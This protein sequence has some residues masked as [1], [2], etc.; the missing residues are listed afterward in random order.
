MNENRNTHTVTNLES[1]SGNE[2][3]AA[4]KVERP[5]PPYCLQIHVIRKRLAD[6]DGLSA[7][8]CID[9]LIKA[10]ILPDDGPRFVK[11]VEYTQEKG[12]EEKTVITIVGI[13]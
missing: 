6:I 10:G 7:K 1:N 11:K 12:E 9:G 8:Y 3:L 4:E 2:L 5:D 13:T